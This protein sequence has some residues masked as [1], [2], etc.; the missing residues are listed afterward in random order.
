MIFEVKGE[1]KAKFKYQPFS[2]R[3][4]ATNE[5]MAV[6]KVKSRIGSNHKCKQ[7]FIKVKEVTSIGK[8]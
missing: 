6:K 2:I 7:R 8:E 4:N 1:F 5:E 3:V